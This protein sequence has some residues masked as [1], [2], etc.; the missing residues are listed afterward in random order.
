MRGSRV[1]K[2][3]GGT[4]RIIVSRPAVTAGL[5]PLWTQETGVDWRGGFVRWD[6]GTGQAGDVETKGGS[7]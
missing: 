2:D 5:S 6:V 7:E 3:G 4:K 1:Y